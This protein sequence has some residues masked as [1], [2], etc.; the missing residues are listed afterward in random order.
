VHRLVTDSGIT[1][2]RIGTLRRTVN[3]PIVVVG[4]SAAETIEP[5][6]SPASGRR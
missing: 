2:E 4:E 1:R 3:F 6:P 5:L